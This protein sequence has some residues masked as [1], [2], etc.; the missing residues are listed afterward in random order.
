LWERTA[1]FLPISADID[2][3]VM[4]QIDNAMNK[5]S[6][7]Y[8]QAAMYYLDNNKDLSKANDWLDK[9]IIQT[10]TAYWVWHQKANCL[11]RLGKK[12]EATVAANKSI[13]LAKAAKNPD[14][15]TLNE[16]LLG[17]LK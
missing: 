9:A 1:V 2:S 7:P 3:K 6:K 14:Y 17:T 12:Q 10:P 16:K 4:A 13:E 5:D 11:A 8:F 15:V